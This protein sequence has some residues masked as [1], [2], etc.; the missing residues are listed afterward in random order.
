MYGAA[1]LLI[2]AL[3]EVGVAWKVSTVPLA[4]FVVLAAIAFAVAC[5]QAVRVHRLRSAMSYG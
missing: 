3:K 5:L 4:T 1:A 2:A